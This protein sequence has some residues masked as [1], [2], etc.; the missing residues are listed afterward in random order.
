MMTLVFEDRA[1]AL[2]ALQPHKSLGDNDALWGNTAPALHACCQGHPWWLIINGAGEAVTTLQKL[3]TM[4]IERA[5]GSEGKC[6]GGTNWG[7]PML[8]QDRVVMM[9]QTYSNHTPERASVQLIEVASTI[10]VSALN[11]NEIA[12][13]TGC[14]HLPRGGVDPG[15][16][17]P[18]AIVATTLMSDERSSGGSEGW[19]KSGAGAESWGEATAAVSYAGLGRAVDTPG[20]CGWQTLVAVMKTEAA[21]GK[22]L[23]GAVEGRNVLGC[24]S[25]GSDMD[26]LERRGYRVD[27][28][29]VSDGIT[30]RRATAAAMPLVSGADHDD[31]PVGG[32]LGYSDARRQGAWLVGKTSPDDLDVVRQERGRYDA[33]CNSGGRPIPRSPTMSAASQSLSG[34]GSGGAPVGGVLSPDDARMPHF[35]E[36]HLFAAASR[37]EALHVGGSVSKTRSGSPSSGAEP[38]REWDRRAGTQKVLVPGAPVGGVLSPDGARLPHSHETHPFAAASRPEA[39]HVGGS[40]SQTRSGSPSSGAEPEWGWDRRAGMQEVLV[41]GSTA[42]Q[43]ISMHDGALVSHSHVGG[44][45][46]QTHGI[47]AAMRLRGGGWSD[48]QARRRHEAEYQRAKWE[49]A[50]AAEWRQ[51]VA[52][53]ERNWVASRGA[54]MVEHGL[55]ARAPCPSFPAG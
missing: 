8:V 37:P 11:A 27:D 7:L 41:P 39:L 15:A 5:S 53:S 3:V 40:V 49:P 47:V 18:H 22:V 33:G 23:A 46:L 36:T 29:G 44:S 43:A 32:G 38:E 4:K 9:W 50:Q 10:S 34:D 17:F 51:W 54:A 21:S 25:L 28:R 14:V 19:R 42:A 12:L 35:H 31:T 16:T 55:C 30:D 24:A 13:I 1:A 6:R 52:S 20:A 45:A 48:E 2:A 26:R